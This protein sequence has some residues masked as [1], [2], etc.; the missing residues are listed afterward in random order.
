[1]QVACEASEQWKIAAK[2]AKHGGALVE[3]VQRWPHAA[4]LRRAVSQQ[5]FSVGATLSQQALE[6]RCEVAKIMVLTMDM[7]RNAARW[8]LSASRANTLQRTH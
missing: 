4:D 7:V 8:E 6:P 3:S 1:M 5:R 2:P